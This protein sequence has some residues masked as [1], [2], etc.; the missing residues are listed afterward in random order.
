MIVSVTAEGRD[1]LGGVILPDVVDKREALTLS[2]DLV[3]GQE[4]SGNV[5]KR[6]EKLLQVRL[7]RIFGKIRN[8]NCGG[9]LSCG[10]EDGRRV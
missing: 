7:L 5:S 1:R 2:G 3:L 10:K 6:L 8:S 9:V 4:D